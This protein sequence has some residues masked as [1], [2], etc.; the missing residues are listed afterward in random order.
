MPNNRG[1][2]NKKNKLTCREI[3]LF[4]KMNYTKQQSTENKN[5]HIHHVP[6]ER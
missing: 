3:I 6:L 1:I 4:D 5:G 2:I